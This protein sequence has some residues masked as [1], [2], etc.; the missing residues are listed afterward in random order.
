MRWNVFDS[1]IVTLA[2]LEWMMA[3]MFQGDVEMP[4]MT[5]VRVIRLMRLVKMLRVIRVLRAFRELRLLVSS[6]LQ[7][8]GALF[9]TSV[10]LMLIMYVFAVFVI[11]LVTE[12]VQMSGLEGALVSEEEA[13]NLQLMTELFENVPIAM[14]SLYQGIS[15]GIDWGDLANPLANGISKWCLLLFCLYTAFFYFAVLNVVTGVFCNE[16]ISA[17]AKD[18]DHIMRE[19]LQRTTSVVNQFKRMFEEADENHDGMVTWTEFKDQV[20]DPRTQAMFKQLE[21]D[22]G[23]ARSLFKLLTS[24]DDGRVPLDRFVLGCL[25]FRGPAKGLEMGI[26]Q[27]KVEVM[28]KRLLSEIRELKALRNGP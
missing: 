27:Y 5:A 26:L 7:S 15:G 12:Q 20:G 28:E 6:I 18:Q 21:L 1:V 3:H 13:E 16:A 14:V 11:Q 10:L 9:W 24:D 19:E 17:S 23:E 8:M 2:L 25:K 22:V 4:N